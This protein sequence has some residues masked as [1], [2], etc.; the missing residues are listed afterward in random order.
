MYQKDAPTL[1]ALSR[2]ITDSANTLQHLLT[3][4][5]LPPPS[6]SPTGRKDWSDAAAHPDILSARSDLIDRTQE[7]LNLV[8]GPVETLAAYSGSM[9]SEIDVLRTLNLLKVHEAVPLDGSLS[10]SDLAAKIGVRDERSLVKQLRFA[11]L[12]GLF[13]QTDNGQVAHTAL[14]AALPESSAWIEWRTGK[15]AS[16]GAHEVAKAILL[17]P[18]SVEQEEVVAPCAL[19][20]P[21]GK[22]RAFWVQIEDVKEAAPGQE[23]ETELYSRAMR[24]LLLHQNS[25]GAAATY[26]QGL[27]WDSLKG[28]TIVDVG[29]GNGHVVV[30]LAPWVHGMSFVVQDRPQNEKPARELI[31]AHRLADRIRFRAHDFLTPQPELPDGKTPVAYLLVRVLQDWSDAGSVRILKPLVRGMEKYRAKTWI[32]GRLL[33]DGFDEMSIHEEKN[34]RNMDLLGFNL[35]GGGDRSERELKSLLGMVDTRLRIN[36]ISRPPQ[37]VLSFV[38]V[39]LDV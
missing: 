7:L 23:T 2:L 15:L 22:N 32:I 18:Q 28:G 9:L 13:R 1:T 3:Q 8:R 10:I 37:S 31:E 30:E 24:G 4:Y 39:V 21:L 26:L 6:V 12:M 25:G 17:R 29:G 5:N 20:D 35:H 38:E 19:A 14:S 11:Y 27:D 16:Q 36:K 34:L 33:P